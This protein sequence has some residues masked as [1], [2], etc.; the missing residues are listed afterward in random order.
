VRDAINAPH[1]SGKLTLPIGSNTLA[2]VF[3]V[4]VVH[5]ALYPLYYL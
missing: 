2:A 5:G 1:L 3:S 4:G